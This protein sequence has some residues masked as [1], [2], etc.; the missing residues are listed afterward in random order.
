[1]YGEFIK[2]ISEYEIEFYLGLSM[3]SFELSA[4]DLILVIA[5]IVLLILYITKSSTKTATEEKQMPKITSLETETEGEVQSPT[6]PPKNSVECPYNFGYLKKLGKDA[7]I[8][9]ECL[10]CSRMMT[11]LYSTE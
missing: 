2:S 4:I 3:L 7:A 10:G 1:M 6:S 11:C 9:D 5:V 8:P